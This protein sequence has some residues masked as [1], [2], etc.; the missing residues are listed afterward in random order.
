ME[1]KF[2][3]RGVG[4]G[5][6]AGLL[7]FVFARI[8]AEPVIAKAIDY[9]DARDQAQAVLDR[10][11]GLAVEVAGSDPFSRTVQEDLGIA[12]ALVVFG[13]ALG[14]L[15]AVVFTLVQRGSGS[16]IRPRTLALLLAAGAFVSVYLVPFLK[17][18]ANPPAVSADDTIEARGSLY[19]GLQV[20]SVIALV[21]CVQLGRRLARDRGSYQAS[22]LAAAAYVV[23]MTV[24]FLVFKDVH[25]TPGPLRDASGRIVLGGFDPDVLYDFR[26]Y[27]LGGQLILWGGIGLIL[28]PWAEKALAQ[29]GRPVVR[30][31]SVPV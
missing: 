10:A 20:V 7:A 4:A 31:E 17:Y 18:P 28:G 6:L 27:A 26:L 14:A 5:A 12:V 13:A 23:A 2:V 22:L 29:A 25:E 16:H 1:K 8:F 30:R 15:L 9:E 21:L 24:A 19:L 11:A 3:L